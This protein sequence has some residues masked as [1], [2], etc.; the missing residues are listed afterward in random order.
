VLDGLR[1]RIDGKR[2]QKKPPPGF[3]MRRDVE[4]KHLVYDEFLDIV[5]CRSL[6]IFF[7][8]E[9]ISFIKAG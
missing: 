4:L 1:R 7:S 6:Q 2:A 5:F 8:P 3:R 9:C